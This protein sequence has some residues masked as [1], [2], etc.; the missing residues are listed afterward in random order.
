LQRRAHAITA[1]FHFGFRKTNQVESG[2]SARKMY[3]DRYRQ[4]VESGKSATVQN[5]ERHDAR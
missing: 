1:L 5:G 2:Q 4:G 3:F